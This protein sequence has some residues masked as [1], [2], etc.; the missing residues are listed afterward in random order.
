MNL[1]NLSFMTMESSQIVLSIVK[2]FVLELQ[3][4]FIGKL[5]PIKVS[6]SCFKLHNDISLI[7]LLFQIDKQLIELPDELS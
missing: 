4:T 6:I 3:K 2:I 5:L 7:L 1:F